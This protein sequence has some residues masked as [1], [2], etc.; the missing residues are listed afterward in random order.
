MNTCNICGKQLQF[1]FT[2]WFCP[3]DCD[4]PKSNDFGVVNNNDDND[5]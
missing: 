2:S 4:K 3:N 5:I 1:L